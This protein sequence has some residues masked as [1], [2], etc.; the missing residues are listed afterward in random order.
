[1]TNYRNLCQ[2]GAELLSLHSLDLCVVAFYAGH[3]YL[4]VPGRNLDPT[5]FHLDWHHWSFSAAD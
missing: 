2:V 1:M 3:S 4:G 5:H